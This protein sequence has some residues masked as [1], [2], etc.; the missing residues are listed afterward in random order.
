M[1]I[2]LIQRWIWRDLGEWSQ[3]LQSDCVYHQ[4][5]KS[6][7]GVKVAP[8]CE[9]N[10]RVEVPPTSV[11]AKVATSIHTIGI[12]CVWRYLVGRYDR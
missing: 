11:W 3:D 6:Y 4:V 10:L 8:C 1:V 2:Q 12:S 7:K 5:T 9:D